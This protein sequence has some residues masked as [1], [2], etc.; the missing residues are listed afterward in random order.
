M[1]SRPP[2]SEPL[3]AKVSARVLLALSRFG[4]SLL[5]VTI[6]LTRTENPLGG[7][8]QR[9]RM[10]A[11]LPLGEE[12]RVESSNGTVKAAVA[13]AAERL[14]RRVADALRDGSPPVAAGGLLGGAAAPRRAPARRRRRPASR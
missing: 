8:D 6:G 1:S 12:I 2:L 9:C 7:V 11:H 13:R 5:R 4:P 10:Q 14:A 3:R